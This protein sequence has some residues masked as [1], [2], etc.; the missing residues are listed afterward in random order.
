[1]AQDATH[2]V[3]LLAA[4][5]GQRLGR[6]IPKALVMLGELSI[7]Q[8][9]AL[10]V[11]RWS[12]HATVVVVQPGEAAAEVHEQIAALSLKNPVLFVDGGN[13]RTESV[14]NGLS[15][16]NNASWVLV[17]DAARALTPPAVFARVAAALAEGADA[18]LPVLPV[19]DTIKRASGTEITESL[20]RSELVAAQTPQGFTAAALL[21]AYQRIPGEFTDDTAQV[22]AAGYRVHSCVG[23]EDSFKITTPADLRAAK[24]LIKEREARMLP[25]YR[26][27]QGSDIHAFAARN[28]GQLKLFGLS[29]PGEVP[30]SGHSDG[31]AALHAIV[32]ALL[33]A[34]GLGDI[35]TIFGSD[36]PEFAQADSRVF[37]AETLRLIQAEGWKIESVSVQLIANRPKIAGRRAEAQALLQE[38]LHSNNVSV[39]ATTSDGLGFTGR[40]EG[41]EARAVALLSRSSASAE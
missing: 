31:D 35:G 20:D 27:G 39:A 41:V 29:W 15:L 22:A 19:V 2:A 16:V 28:S 10:G 18:V 23:A 21:D 3:I 30:L 25:E 33:G 17:H 4:G 37:I 11:A 12:E 6:G 14:R 32:D 1:M 13:S 7:L 40:G 34:A 36:R 24:Q 38:L 9:A 5:S 8:R 26:I